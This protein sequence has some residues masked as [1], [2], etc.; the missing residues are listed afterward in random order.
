MQRREQ[1]RQYILYNIQYTTTYILLLTLASLLVN[2]HAQPWGV[3]EYSRVVSS[4]QS[5]LSCHCWSMGCNSNLSKNSTTTTKKHNEKS[6]SLLL[7]V[8]YNNMPP[9]CTA[10]PVSPV[11]SI[12]SCL[13]L[14]PHCR[15]IKA[16]VYAVVFA[17][18]FSYWFIWFMRTACSFCC[19]FHAD[20]ISCFASRDSSVEVLFLG[21]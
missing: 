8:T 11:S 14:S 5:P 17:I 15:P 10:T 4:H 13:P 1:V 12:A 16:V 7:Q 20:L 21:G 19:R 9:C 6:P 2:K 18:L 3:E